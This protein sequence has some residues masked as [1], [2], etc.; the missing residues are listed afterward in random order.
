MACF[1]AARLAAESIAAPDE[2]DSGR[3]SRCAGAKAWLG[4]LSLPSAVRGPVARCAELSVRGQAGEVGTEVAR[5]AQAAATYLDTQSRAELAA[6]A[7][8]LGG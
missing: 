3:A 4:T 2:D 5:L 6:L 1:V 7:A 8:S